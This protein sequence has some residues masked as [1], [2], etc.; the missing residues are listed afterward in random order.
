MQGVDRQ[1]AAVVLVC[2]RARQYYYYKINNTAVHDYAIS[3]IR[4]RKS[5]K[6]LGDVKHI[7]S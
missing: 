3:P 5:H 2:R 1:A 7:A 6:Q 4:E